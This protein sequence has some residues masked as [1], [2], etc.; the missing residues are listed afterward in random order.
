LPKQ[1]DTKQN[2]KSSAAE[3]HNI[4]HVVYLL[5][6]YDAIQNWNLLNGRRLLPVQTPVPSAIPMFMGEQF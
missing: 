1:C 4:G 6:L 5:D 3:K 2:G